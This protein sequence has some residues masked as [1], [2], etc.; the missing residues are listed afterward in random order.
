MRGDRRRRGPRLRRAG[1]R[2]P[3]DWPPRGRGAGDTDREL[4][5]PYRGARLRGDAL[6]PA[7]RHLGRRRGRSSRRC[8]EAVR[9]V[10][11][12][13][14]WLRAVR[15]HGRG[16][17]RRRRD[18][19]A[20]G[21]AALGRRRGRRRPAA[22]RR[23]GARPRDR[24]ARVPAAAA[25]PGPAGAAATPTADG[26]R[27]RPA[28][29][30]ARRSRTGCAA[31]TGRWCSATT[32][33]PT[34]PRN[35]RVSVAVD[36]LTVHLL[37][38]RADTALA[39]LATPTDV[40]AVPAEAVEQSGGGT[41]AARRLPA[42]AGRCGWSAA[43]GCCGATTRPAPTRASTTAWCRSRAPTTRS[44][45]G[46]SG[47]G[48]RSPATT[49]PPCRCNVAPPTRTRSVVKNRVLAAAYAGA[50]RFGVEVFE[51]ATRNML[52]AALLVHDLRPAA[53]RRHA[54]PVAGR[55]DAAAPR[56]AVADAVRA[57]QRP[58]PRRAARHRR[59]PGLPRLVLAHEPG[60]RVGA[61][62]RPL[63]EPGR[64]GLLVTPLE[65]V[66]AGRADIGDP[67]ARGR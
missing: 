57:A 14:D 30:P 4:S 25:R 28:H 1:P 39:F 26:R 20:A 19:P 50:H 67:G 31:A 61:G 44:P 64:E 27:R 16:A 52:M 66:E 7:A 22:A 23:S 46:C 5:L 3:P 51:P 33:T 54:A 35:V 43:G 29:R 36:A 42:A 58:R 53:A 2:R 10:L 60:G 11:A 21:A 8:A 47:G 6:A 24:P 34:A 12:N 32:S 13:P 59:S 55:G 45:S 40:F 38:Q 17:R 56:R 37:G 18:G 65:R 41:A 49:A 9:T 62:T 48:P 63:V 15:P